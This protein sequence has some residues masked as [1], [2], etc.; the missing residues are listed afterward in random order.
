M[1]VIDGGSDGTG[2]PT[3][4]GFE[5][6]LGSS[7]E[8]D[9]AARACSQWAQALSNRAG[10]LKQGAQQAQSAWEGPARTAFNG[11]ASHLIS[12]FNATSEA[13]GKAG[14]A[15]TA[16]AG[17]LESCQRVTR[18]AYQSCEQAQSEYET[19]STAASTHASTVE[20][21]TTQL[22][23][24]VTPHQSAA[25]NRQLSA[26]Q[27]DQR[28]AESA[29]ARAQAALTSAQRQGQQAWNQYLQQ[30]ANASS[31]LVNLDGQL[32]QVQAV[33][34][35]QGANAQR[36]AAAGSAFWTAFD[37]AAG[38]D[39]T[40]SAIGLAQAIADRYRK[41]SL[42][43]PVTKQAD[44]K[45]ESWLED[46]GDTSDNYVELP[47]GIWVGKTSDANPLIGEVRAAT[48]NG[49]W[50]TPGKGQL[51][52]D[53]EEL[54]GAMPT[55][56]KGASGGLFI[57]GSGLTLYSTG[58][59]QWQ[60]DEKNHPSWSTAEKVADTAQTTV[61]V[62]GSSVGGAYVG[63]EVGGEAGMEGGAA[64]GTFICP[65]IGTAVGG[66]VGGI[67]GAV[68]GGVVGS[69]VGKVV[70]QDL[71]GAGHWAAHEASHIWNS[72]F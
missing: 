48:S 3:A 7:G 21:L 65:G 59:S 49:E 5:I 37:D 68:V 47:N 52:P 36:A 58:E 72:I 34:R 13:V 54:K 69:H 18:S 51:I 61:V 42:V 1:R 41:T 45:L 16:F 15:L 30:A 11:Y 39:V 27:G 28:A 4:F 20:S 32:Q 10:N 67:G 24:A 14:S 64:I 40:G 31:T 12:V 38:S 62:G 2:T 35:R 22:S 66:V 53:A 33:P 25:L 63:A 6:P 9:A 26:A 23:T 60:Y 17:E 70:G 44:Q 43:L 8:L 71:E 50:T 56:A 46:F 29:A 19:Q 57:V 55:W